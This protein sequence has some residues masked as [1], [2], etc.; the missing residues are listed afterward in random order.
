MFLRPA[1]FKNIKL[2]KKS[3]FCSSLLKVQILPFVTY[4]K[5]VRHQFSEGWWSISNFSTS[6]FALMSYSQKQK[7]N[8]SL[9]HPVTVLSCCFCALRVLILSLHIPTINLF[10]PQWSRLDMLFEWWET[11]V[12]W[13]HPWCL[14]HKQGQPH[15]FHSYKSPLVSS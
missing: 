9:G 7:T 3:P 13:Q 11:A 4:T 5:C 6:S 10:H 2:V 12:T 14:H 8:S 15:I 1:W